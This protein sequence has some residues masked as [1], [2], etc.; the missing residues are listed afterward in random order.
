MV[1][2]YNLAHELEKNDQKHHEQ[3]PCRERASGVRFGLGV[4][5]RLW[6]IERSA[7]KGGWEWE[8]SERAGG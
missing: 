3:A 6:E 7:P 4:A 2:P 5:Y 1:D 8:R